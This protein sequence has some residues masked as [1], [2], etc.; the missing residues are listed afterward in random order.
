MWRHRLAA[1]EC[2]AFRTRHRRRMR[3]DSSDD[4]ECA[5]TLV[6]TTTGE[7]NNVPVSPSLCRDSG[8]P[9]EAPRTGKIAQKTLQRRYGVPDRAMER[10]RREASRW[11][12]RSVGA[13]S[14]G[15]ASRAAAP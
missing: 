10:S 7:A 4:H 8:R 14:H 6:P 15:R 13:A 11:T 1:S 5:A 3:I 9:C 2:A 12:M